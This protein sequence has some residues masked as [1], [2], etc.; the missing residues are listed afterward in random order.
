MPSQVDSGYVFLLFY[1]AK[2]AKKAFGVVSSG[3]RAPPFQPVE[4][5]WKTAENLQNTPEKFGKNPQQGAGQPSPR[6]PCLVSH[7][8]LKSKRPEGSFLGLQLMF[9]P[10]ATWRRKTYTK[11]TAP[12]STTAQ[13]E[14]R[15]AQI[16]NA[17]LQA[18]AE[19][20][21]TEWFTLILNAGRRNVKKFVLTIPEH[22]DSMKVP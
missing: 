1:R 10:R 18:G 5:S 4:T 15:G 16:A 21:K 13:E 11:K 2:S 8:G 3:K 22:G 19:R 17:S 14:R 7:S 12:A 20:Q 6:Q 9:S